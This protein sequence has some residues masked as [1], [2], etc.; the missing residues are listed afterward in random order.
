VSSK[1]LEQLSWH[2]ALLAPADEED[3]PLRWRLLRGMGCGC[4]VW[5]SPCLLYAG[6]APVVQQRPWC[7]VGDAHLCV[8]ACMCACV[9]V[10]VCV[11][12]LDM[13]L[14]ACVCVCVRVRVRV[15]IPRGM[16]IEVCIWRYAY[17]G[18]HIEVCI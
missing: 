7:A 9:R 4:G 16:H 8:C 2:A 6:A 3:L 13:H 11:G 14:P 10:C 18:M 1:Y 15:R 17:R 12:R 5:Q